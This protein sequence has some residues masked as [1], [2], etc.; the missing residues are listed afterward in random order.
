MIFVIS[1]LVQ[2]AMGV[3]VRAWLR[4]L[5]FVVAMLVAGGL[6]GASL[7]TLGIASRASV[8]SHFF[9][10]TIILIAALREMGVLRVKIPSSEWQVPQSWG[11]RH[12]YRG[13]ILYG[14]SL[15]LGFLTK[16]PYAS[17]HLLLIW[18]ALSGSIQASCIAG[19]LFAACRASGLVFAAFAPEF[20]DSSNQVS[21]SRRMLSDNGQLHL[22]NGFVLAIIASA[23]LM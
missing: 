2:G 14:Y 10:A 3:K 7:A 12:Y 21:A 9:A 5:M 16:A 22:L 6:V 20:N 4:A 19:L 11:R 18:C 13:A 8:L 17:F 15:G 23:T 1:P